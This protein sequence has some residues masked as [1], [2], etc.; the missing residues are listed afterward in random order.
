MPIPE[1]LPFNGDK[2][3]F[4]SLWIIPDYLKYDH[5][6]HAYGFGTATWVCWEALRRTLKITKPSGGVLV[7]IVLIGLGL[8]AVNEIVE[9]IA[10][11][12]IPNTNVGGYINTGWDLISNS[13]GCI[14][15][16]ALIKY[17]S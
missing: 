7:A 13:V 1:G 8:G 5:L 11:L 2:A 14:V 6:I 10:V 17:R 15:A 12:L 16:A 9:F 4:Y 3:V